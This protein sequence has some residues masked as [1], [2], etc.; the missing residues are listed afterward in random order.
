MANVRCG[1]IFSDDLCLEPL[2]RKPVVL[3]PSVLREV[4]ERPV[5][6]LVLK[7]DLGTSSPLVSIVVLTYNN[8]LLN[9]L[10]LE[11]V[12]ANTDAPEFELI[13]VDNGSSDTTPEY[14]QALA[15]ANANEIGRA[16]V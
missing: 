1:A 10:C 4:L 8:L 2:S 14:L 13:V 11:S 6:S 5:P 7:H 3:H 12:L 15:G 16:H 9:R